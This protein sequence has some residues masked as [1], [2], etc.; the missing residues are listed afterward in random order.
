MLARLRCPSR[1]RGLGLGLIL[2]AVWL[3]TL[4]PAVRLHHDALQAVSSIAGAIICGH[5]PASPDE[6]GP[7]NPAHHR[8]HTCPFCRA[9]GIGPVAEAPAPPILRLVW[10][11]VAW[12]MPPP[13]VLRQATFTS[14][15]ARAPPTA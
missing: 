14:R 15:R 5:D 3:Q 12:P 7:T 8:D 6:P 9:P 4:A 13:P 11:P 10:N 1:A 2:L